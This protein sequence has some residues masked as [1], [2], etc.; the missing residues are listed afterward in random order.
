MGFRKGQAAALD[1]AAHSR[2]IADLDDAVEGASTEA[3]IQAVGGRSGRVLW[4]QARLPGR[5]VASGW[6]R[7]GS[8]A[9]DASGHRDRLRL[10]TICDPSVLPS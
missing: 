9:D 1:S 4:L 6:R 5:G 10:E 7:A 2:R 8:D 3:L